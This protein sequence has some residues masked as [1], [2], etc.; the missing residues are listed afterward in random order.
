LLKAVVKL[1]SREK[2]EIPMYQ[3]NLDVEELIDWIRAMDKYFDYKDVD[4]EKKVK[5]I[6]TRLNRHAT[7]SWDVLQFDRRRK[8]KQKINI[9]DRMVA[10]IKD[11]FIPK[12]YQ[13]NMFRRL[14]NLRQKGMIVKE[15]RKEFYRLNIRAG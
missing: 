9:W 5:H 10:K 2:I 12:D 13:I 8:G 4:E 3:G 14:Q 15:Y 6:V 7:L 1:G 11:K